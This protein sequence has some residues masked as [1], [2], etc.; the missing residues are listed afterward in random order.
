MWDLGASGDL[1]YAVQAVWSHFMFF[2]LPL[3]T[4]HDITSHSYL[5]AA[6]VQKIFI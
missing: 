6:N 2:F 1:D 3:K 5:Y 4:C